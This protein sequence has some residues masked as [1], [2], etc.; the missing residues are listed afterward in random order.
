[1]HFGLPRLTYN[2]VDAD[3]YCAKDHRIGTEAF[4][5]YPRHYDPWG[6]LIPEMQPAD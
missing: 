4:Y 3:Q 6:R 2:D 1:M 5:K